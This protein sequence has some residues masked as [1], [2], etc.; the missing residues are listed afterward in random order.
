MEKIKKFIDCY[1]PIEHCNFKCHYCYIPTLDNFN[2][3]NRPI[4]YTPQF[5]R[6]ALSKERWGGACM[7]NLCA[8]GETLLS[9]DIVPIT[10]EL[11]EEGHYVMIVTNG[12]ITPRFNEIAEF[13]SEIMKRLFFKFS[14][15]YLELKRLNL[16]DIFFNNVKKMKE[17]GASFTIEI[18]PNDEY[19][20]Y[21]NEMKKVCLEEVGAIPH[22]TVARIE[23]GEIPI[24]TKLNKEDYVKTWSVFDSQLFDFKIRIF[25]EKRNEFCYAGAWAYVLDIA[26]GDLRQCYR[27]RTIQNIYKDINEKIKEE[28]IGCSC[29][30][31]HCF[32][33]HAF[34]AFGV[35]PELESPTFAEERNRVVENDE[36]L[37]TEMNQ[38]MKTKLKDSNTEYDE[39]QKR[40]VNRKNEQIDNIQK[41]KIKVKKI[42][43]KK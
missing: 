32:N 31:P 11:L 33:G 36:W 12:S 41:L 26:T 10:K 5:I 39:K 4:E 37:K 40:R 43:R 21:I 34:L 27:G 1:V 30:E 15:H 24:M 42:I 8:G 9:K 25:G 28:P 2:N 18:T 17:K 19:I 29:K 14:F 3:K 13:P 7:I 16:M 6:K 35:I 23:N 20:P 38:F 22:V